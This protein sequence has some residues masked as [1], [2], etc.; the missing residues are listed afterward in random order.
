M[1][2]DL[3][4]SGL[5]ISD[6]SIQTGHS[7][8]CIVRHLKNNNVY[9]ADEAIARGLDKSRQAKIK[10]IFCYDLKGKLLHIYNSVEEISTELNLTERT[11]RRYCRDKK[12]L[13]NKIYSYQEII[14]ED[15]LIYYKNSRGQGVIQYDKNGKFVNIFSSITEATKATN[16]QN[17]SKICKEKKGSAG[18]YQWRYLNDNPPE[19]LKEHT[20]KVSK[21]T[22]D[23]VYIETYNSVLEAALK[24]HI[25]SSSNIN[26]AIKRNG[27]CGGYRWK[28]E[29][30]NTI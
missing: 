22:K 21:Y 12:I 5:T 19:P 3:W 15:L 1:L 13:N 7:R 11:I 14:E 17:I 16:I 10:Q 8:D 27:T 4:K 30:N 24:N 9:N 26:S 18:G 28:Y 29:D 23:W 2:I 25:S 20:K 6:I